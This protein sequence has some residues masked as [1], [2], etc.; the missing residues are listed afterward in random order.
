MA[1]NPAQ[2]QAMNQQMLSLLMA[3]QS[4][5]NPNFNLLNQQAALQQF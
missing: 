3:Q 5:M 1:N 4:V 2:Q